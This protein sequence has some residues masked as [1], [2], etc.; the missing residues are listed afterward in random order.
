MSILID[1]LIKDNDGSIMT[2]CDDNK[3]YIA[4][5]VSFYSLKTKI[6]RFKDAFKVIS[7]KAFAVHYKQDE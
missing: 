7:G 1:K 2:S 5:P 4:K 3:W 6:N